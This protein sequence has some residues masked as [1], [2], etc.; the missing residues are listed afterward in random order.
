MAEIQIF[1][2][3]FIFF[4]GDQRFSWG[5]S[6]QTNADYLKVTI[7]SSLSLICCKLIFIAFAS[8]VSLYVGL[9]VFRKSHT[10]KVIINSS[11]RLYAFFSFLFPFLIFIL[12]LCFPAYFLQ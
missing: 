9:P 1:V 10:D 11:L 3:S 6:L 4:P 12:I 7:L 5:R 2:Y 8:C